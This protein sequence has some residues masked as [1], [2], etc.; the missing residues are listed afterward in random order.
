MLLG[1]RVSGFGL[2]GSRARVLG[3]VLLGSR[4]L[5]FGRLGL[6]ALRFQGPC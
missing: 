2:L 3:V 5:G 6:W 1:S 4:V